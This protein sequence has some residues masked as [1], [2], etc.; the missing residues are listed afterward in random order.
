L[1]T[2]EY[3]A[4]YSSAL[5]ASRYAI[6][7]AF[8]SGAE[9]TVTSGGGKGVSVALPGRKPEPPV[10]QAHRNAMMTMRFSKRKNFILSLSYYGISQLAGILREQAL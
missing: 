8:G 5:Y 10:P 4:L 7:A 9:F 2:S 1:L 3:I 6:N